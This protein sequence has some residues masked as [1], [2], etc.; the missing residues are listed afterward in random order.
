MIVID[1]FI[2]DQALIDEIKGD[3]TFFPPNMGDMENIGHQNNYFHSE[4]SSCYAPY[5]FWDGW[6]ASPA[7]TPRKRV[8]EKIWKTP[9]L[10]KFDTSELCG[11]EY[12]C[13]T[14]MP[15]QHLRVHVDEDT[16]AYAANRHFNAPIIG[17]IWYG[18]TECNEGGFLEIHDGVIEGNPVDA[19]EMENVNKIIS[20]PEKRERLAYR[21][22]RLVSF[23]A[24]R[25]L[26]G[27]TPALE[28]VRQVMVVNV[29]HK[30]SPPLALSTGEFVYE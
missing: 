26:H 7:N 29:W 2:T 19:L 20:P 10:L 17:S 15:G 27:T 11:F 22:N 25:R 16:F 12:W 3:A 5:M 9:G 8:I 23:D 30:S 24:G 28:G 18:F 13:R 1:D 6:W 14:F 21:P 4:A